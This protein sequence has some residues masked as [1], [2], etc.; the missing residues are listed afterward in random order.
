MVWPR[1][2]PVA[3]WWFQQFANCQ[4]Y[5]ELR[6]LYSNLG[7]KRSETG[8]CCWEDGFH[9]LRGFSA[10]LEN[11]HWH[12]ML[13]CSSLFCQWAVSAPEAVSLLPSTAAVFK[14]IIKYRKGI[15]SLTFFIGNTIF[16]MISVLN[17]SYLKTL[18]KDGTVPR[19]II[20]RKF[21]FA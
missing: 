1:V 19:D 9:S 21:Y 6:K 5:S 2:W 11:L 14:Q 16:L 10:V 8:M 15:M 7:R 13:P 12:C 4:T 3:T 18:H 17:W 20:P